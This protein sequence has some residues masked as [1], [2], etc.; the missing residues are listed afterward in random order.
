MAI[1]HQVSPAFLPDA[2]AGNCQRL[3]LRWRCT[4]AQKWSQSM[5]RL[6]RYHPV[7]VTSNQ[8]IKM[9]HLI[10]FTVCKCH[11]VYS[12]IKFYLIYSIGMAI[13]FCVWKDWRKLYMIVFIH[14]HLPVTCRVL[15]LSNIDLPDEPLLMKKSPVFDKG[16]LHSFTC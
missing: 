4:I 16:L 1:S 7:K 8:Y 3:K 6:V 10:F 5:G 14:P 9:Q 12:F 15:C 2:S 11:Y 13:H